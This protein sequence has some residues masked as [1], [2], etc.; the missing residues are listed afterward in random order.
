MA[1]RTLEARFEGLTV[2]DENDPGDGGKLYTKTKVA[3]A[4]KMFPSLRA[5]DKPL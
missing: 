4:S 1:T 2:N 3:F 5:A